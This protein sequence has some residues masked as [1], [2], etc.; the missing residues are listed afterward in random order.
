MS[1]KNQKDLIVEKGKK[2]D[3]FQR[4]GL[5]KKS[6]ENVEANFGSIGEIVPD[7]KKKKKK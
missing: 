1:K 4:D 5:G 6:G 2:K 3:S 7:K